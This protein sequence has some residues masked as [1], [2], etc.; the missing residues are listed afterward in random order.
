MDE[1]GIQES[2]V[3]N[4]LE[5]DCLERLISGYVLEDR[6]SNA[7]V[8]EQ[9]RQYDARRNNKRTIIKKHLIWQL[10]SEYGVSFTPEESEKVIA[11]EYNAEAKANTPAAEA[12]KARI[13][14][15]MEVM[16]VSESATLDQLESDCVAR[17]CV[18]YQSADEKLATPCLKKFV[19]T[20][21]GKIKGL[22]LKKVQGRIEDIWSAEDGE[23]FDNLY[24][25]TNIED[26]AQK[27]AAIA[28]IKEKGRT[29]SSAK[30]LNAV[31][32]CT[33]DN[34]KKA[35][36]Y[37][38]WNLCM[39]I[40][41]AILMIVSAILW[42]AFDVDIYLCALLTLAGGVLLY[43]RSKLKEI[44]NTL[45]IQGTIFHPQIFSEHMPTGKTPVMPALQVCISAF[46][47]AH[48]GVFVLVQC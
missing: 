37:V 38:S 26:Q 20:G 13:L 47:W 34:I 33:P 7:T 46:C 8:L 3:L 19:H 17:L 4:T 14:Y 18:N 40:S 16:G 32:S 31:T 22:Y 1:M 12:A 48:V 10:G 42:V 24:L 5:C 30:Y 29:S 28:Y 15:K 45:T 27:D 23:I 35:T 39:A 25:K 21:A 43:F 11:P 2:D 44:W 41:A 6:P 9:F 36:A